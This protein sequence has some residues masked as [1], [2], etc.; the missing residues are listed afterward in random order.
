MRLSAEVAGRQLS[1]EVRR[2][3]EGQY[4]VAVG[5]HRLSV[6]ARPIGAHGFS[7]LVDGTSHDTA[8]E[9]TAGGFRVHLDGAAVEVTLREAGSVAMGSP[10]GSGPSQVRAPMPGRIVR[11]LAAPGA[12]VAVGDGLVIVEAMKMENEL[13]AGR[14]GTV[15]AVHVREGQAVEGGALLVELE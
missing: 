9:R 1:V 3:A 4:E 5:E 2:R 8:V 6:E 10:T 15:K 12:E 13:K 7:L 14:A 11:V